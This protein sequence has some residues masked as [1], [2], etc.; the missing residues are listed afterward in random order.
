MQWS[1]AHIHLGEHHDHDGSHHEHNVETHA[2]QLVGHH[3]SSHHTETIDSS[4]STSDVK[5]VSIDHECSTPKGKKQEKPSSAP[6]TL[7]IQQLAFSQ[8]ISI[9]LPVLLNTRLSHIDRSTV[10]LRAPPQFS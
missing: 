1:A 8:S 4:H 2:H 6:I 3:S 5:V 9:A 10:N 7:G